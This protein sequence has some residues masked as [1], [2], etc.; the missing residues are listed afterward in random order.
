MFVLAT[1]VNSFDF[2]RGA[3]WHI[4]TAFIERSRCCCCCD[5]TF[6]SCATAGVFQIADERLRDASIAA[7]AAAIESVEESFVQGSFTGNEGEEDDWLANSDF[8]KLNIGDESPM[9]RGERE[10]G[11]TRACRGWYDCT[12]TLSEFFYYVNMLDEA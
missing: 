7:R 4:V 10:K 11:A 9:V 1:L 3:S 6:L 8:V 2:F 12:I 5:L